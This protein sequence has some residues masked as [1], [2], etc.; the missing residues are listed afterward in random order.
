MAGWNEGYGH[1]LGDCGFVWTFLVSAAWFRRALWGK[2]SK[3]PPRD[4]LRE[5]LLVAAS[6]VGL[7][8]AERAGGHGSD[9]LDDA[10]RADFQQREA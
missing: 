6:M 2:K 4:F 8:P 7:L 9:A 10:H 1:H 3:L 5:N